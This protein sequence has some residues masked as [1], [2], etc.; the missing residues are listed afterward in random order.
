MSGVRLFDLSWPEKPESAKWI[1]SRWR[2]E[3]GPYLVSW[4]PEPLSGN[5]LISAGRERMG[6]DRRLFSGQWDSCGLL[7]ASLAPLSGLLWPD[8]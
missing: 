4:F 3:P 6:V 7:E 5:W 2:I 8:V 1:S